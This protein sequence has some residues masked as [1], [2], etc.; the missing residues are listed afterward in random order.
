MAAFAPATKIQEYKAKYPNAPVVLYVNSLAESKAKCDVVCTSSNA[1]RVVQRLQ[2]TTGAKQILF[3]PDANLARYVH[4]KTGIDIEVIDGKT[5]ADIIFFDSQWEKGDKNIP[6]IFAD[7]GGGSTEIRVLEKKKSI[8]C[9][10]NIGT[11]RI[12]MDMVSSSD[13]ENMKRWVKE[14]IGPL[15]ITA[16][17]ASGGNIHKILS[18]SGNKKARRLSINQMRKVRKIL[19]S[20]NLIE[21]ITILGLKPDRADVI[22]PALKIYFL[23]MKWSKI[24]TYIVPQMGLADG[25]I[26]QLYFSYHL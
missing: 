17:M 4:E 5:E 7:V 20:Y 24:K 14:Q 18:L 8:S 12:L 23:I 2:E 22:L 1:V 16:A 15:G 21:R 10:F 6:E 26:R 25:I 13:W 19:T 11:I 9:S 3:G